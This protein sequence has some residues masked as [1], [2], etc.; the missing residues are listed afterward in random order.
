MEG[1]DYGRG[2][3]RCVGDRRR[4]CVERV[5]GRRRKRERRW[6]RRRWRRT[7][8]GGNG[9]RSARRRRKWRRAELEVS[10]RAG[11]GPEE[12]DEGRTLRGVGGGG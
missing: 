7:D 3:G 1:E 6:E 4:R 10:G 12:E 5:W 2:E 8:D 11:S 9:C